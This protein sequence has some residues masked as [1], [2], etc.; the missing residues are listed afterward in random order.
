MG[1]LV[2]HIDSVCPICLARIPARL[3]EEGGIVRM[4]KDCPQHG[5]F[6]AI[7]WRGLPSFQS[8]SRP[9]IAYRGGLRDTT[10]TRGCPF[11]CG[12]CPEHRQRTCTAL[13]EVTG[14]CNLKCP[15]CFADSGGN[16]GAEPDLSELSSRFQSIFRKTGGCNLQISG[17]EPTLRGD[18]PLVIEKARQAGFEFV[19]LNTNGLR[20]AAEKDLAAR[21]RDAGL[22]SVF[23]QFDGIDDGVYRVLRGRSLL[24]VKERAVEN[25]AR[26][27]LSV[28]LVATIARGVNEESLGDIVRFG[29]ARQPA[30]RGVH[31]QP[32]SFFGRYPLSLKK[33]H[34]T[35][36]E[37]MS[38]LV[39]QAQLRH[40]DF[41]PPGCEHALC[42]FS[43]RYLVDEEGQ[44]NRLGSQAACDCRPVAA[45]AGALKA[46]AVTARQ[47]GAVS[48]G[49]LAT[50]RSDDA[51]GLFLAR[52][53]T[54]IFSISAMAFQDA[55]NL[56]LERLQGCCIHV[57]PGGDRLVPFCA[58]N[59]TARDGHSLYRSRP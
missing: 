50:E 3:V 42:S 1:E 23:L 33:E 51:F 25:L 15:V 45:E 18:L 14:R 29:I 24:A 58:Y 2:G 32:L 34:V 21:Y 44:L 8:W 47:W 28:V 10:G 52:A 12:L 48:P 43:A 54:H 49:K 59:L 38:G 55:E 16:A 11:D 30:V 31:L 39:R 53:R 46:I 13:V 35:L 41:R 9:K 7:L 22:S 17:G 5:P 20:L 36:P 57:A 56:N 27:G 4:E 26:A 6:S 37:L 19:Q 40:D